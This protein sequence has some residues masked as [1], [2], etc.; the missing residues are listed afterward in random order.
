MKSYKE[1]PEIN[2]VRFSDDKDSIMVDA[3]FKDGQCYLSF[4]ST[5]KVAK[6][7]ILHG[8]NKGHDILEYITSCRINNWI[9]K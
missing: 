9:R 8:I 3:I 1:F 7:S 4:E 5:E 6:W 2:K